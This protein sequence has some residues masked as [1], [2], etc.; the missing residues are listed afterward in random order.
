MRQW[1]A[2]APGAANAW[3]NV[4]PSASSPESN[5]PSS[6]VTVWVRP[7]TF[8]QVTVSPGSASTVLGEN[9]WNRMLTCGGA[10]AAA[11]APTA[12]AASAA[13]PDDETAPGLRTRPT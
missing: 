11:G 13:R 9:A 8:G 6:A 7:L 10:A 1:Y 4:A 12:S 2:N 3:A 5:E